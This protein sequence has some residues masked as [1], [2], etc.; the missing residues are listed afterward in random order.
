MERELASET[1]RGKGRGRAGRTR[2]DEI[3]M[4]DE[5]TEEIRPKERMPMDK[6]MAS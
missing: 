5:E 2:E 4:E 1:A 6:K 3:K